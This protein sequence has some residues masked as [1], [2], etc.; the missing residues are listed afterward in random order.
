M[1]MPPEQRYVGMQHGGHFRF[2]RRRADHLWIIEKNI[3][4]SKLFFCILF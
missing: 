4:A 2:F 3:E 1:P